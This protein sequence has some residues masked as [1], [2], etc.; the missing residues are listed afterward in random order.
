MKNSTSKAETKASKKAKPISPKEKPQ[1]KIHQG[2]R[3]DAK[4]A[5]HSKNSRV[6]EGGSFQETKNKR[7]KE[8][9]QKNVT[10]TNRAE[11]PLDPKSTAT[12]KLEEA[13]YSLGGDEE[14]YI[15]LKDVNDDGDA[16]L[17]K[18]DGGVEDVGTCN[19]FRC[20]Y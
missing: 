6:D 8:S 10:V 15:L 16:P 2:E 19:S 1:K 18:N 7:I 20:K 11:K 3:N 12:S 4:S 9:N 14:D 5:N 13:I 17:D